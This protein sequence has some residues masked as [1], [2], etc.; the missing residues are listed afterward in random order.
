MRIF[1]E[2]VDERTADLVR[3]SATQANTQIDAH[4]VLR[5]RGLERLVEIVEAGVLRRDLI[6][7]GDERFEEFLVGRD[8]L[9]DVLVEFLRLEIFEISSTF[10]PSSFR[11]LMKMLGSTPPF[12]MTVPSFARSVWMHLPLGK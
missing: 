6:V 1:L 10:R 3:P 8:L 4:V 12:R 9:V 7:G 5:Q 11:G 2:V